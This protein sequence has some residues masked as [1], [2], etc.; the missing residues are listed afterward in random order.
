MTQPEVVSLTRPEEFFYNKAYLQTSIA[1][2][3]FGLPEYYSSEDETKKAYNVNS[4]IYSLPDVN[5]NSITEPWLLY[6][7]NDKFTLESRFGNLIN[8]KGI[9]SDQLLMF[10][11]DALQLQ[12]SVNQFTD[13]STQYNSELGNGGMF[14]KRA[15]TL[16][17]TD[18]GN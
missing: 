5:E 15:I 7:P 17:S 14:A 3:S 4:G 18:I 8:V 1:S 9:E 16:R 13:G 2:S 10:F 11:E 6:R 12:N